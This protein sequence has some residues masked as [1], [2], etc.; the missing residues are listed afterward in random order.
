MRVGPWLETICPVSLTYRY[1]GTRGRTKQIPSEVALGFLR[2]RPTPPP[3]TASRR[4]QRSS[5]PGDADAAHLPT[6]PTEST[7]R[8]CRLFYE[9]DLPC[10]LGFPAATPRSFARCSP[11]PPHVFALGVTSPSSGSCVPVNLLLPSAPSFPCQ[12][13]N[14]VHSSSPL[15][16]CYIPAGRCPLLLALKGAAR[17]IELPRMGA[18][19]PPLP[20]MSALPFLHKSRAS[21]EEDE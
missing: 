14:P 9:L 21:G 18:S 13:S 8:R 15:T 17:E 10:P 19:S 3:Q 2:H 5:P 4:R 16:P 20:V 11:R 7:S 12:P 1:R 6:L